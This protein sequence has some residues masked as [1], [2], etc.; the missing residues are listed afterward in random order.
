MVGEADG[1]A[2]WFTED[3][4]DK[5]HGEEA[6][7][8]DGNSTV[9]GRGFE[10]DIEV[11]WRCWRGWRATTGDWECGEIGGDGGEECRVRGEGVA[12]FEGWEE[13][14]LGDEFLELGGGRRGEGG[15]RGV[16]GGLGGEGD[17][18]GGGGGVFRGF[19]GGGFCGC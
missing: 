7:D 5:T 1:S 16:G 11:F 8:A 19:E 15:G 12:G 2:G 6:M 10:G 4:A 3:S 14:V 9:D 13:V 17:G 18:E